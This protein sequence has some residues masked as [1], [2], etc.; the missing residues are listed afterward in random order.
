MLFRSAR[1][2]GRP[3]CLLAGDR[4]LAV[5]RS[6]EG[7]ARLLLEADLVWAESAAVAEGLAAV[8]RRPASGVVVGPLLPE[9]AP[10]RVSEE[11][12]LVA[13]AGPVAFEADLETLVE[14]L[15]DTGLGLEIVGLPE[16]SARGEEAAYWLRRKIAGR[17]GGIIWRESADPAELAALFRR[18]DIVFS[19][20]AG[21]DGKGSGTLPASALAALGAGIPVIASRSSHSD[22]LLRHEAEALLVEPGDAPGLAASLRRLAG[23]AGLRARLGAAG[24]AR[25]ADLERAAGEVLERLRALIG[26]AGGPRPGT[27]RPGAE[28]CSREGP[29]KRR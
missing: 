9:P 28:A 1:L 23:D 6:M 12:K 14:A 27:A 8:A 2:L 22:P 10:E 13:A 25:F 7:G 4:D 3:F 24:K 16:P 21:A 11:C 29:L 18:A 17:P 20:G 15:G 26:G 19:A 5:L